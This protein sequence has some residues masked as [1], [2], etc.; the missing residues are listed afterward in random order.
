MSVAVCCVFYEKNQSMRTLWTK[1]LDYVYKQSQKQPLL[2]PYRALEHRYWSSLNMSPEWTSVLYQKQAALL[3]SSKTLIG[4][5]WWFDLY[6]SALWSW[7]LLCDI[8]LPGRFLKKWNRP[9]VSYCHGWLCVRCHSFPLFHPF[10]FSLNIKM[11]YELHH[12]C[13][14]GGVSLSFCRCNMFD[15]QIVIQRCLK[16]TPAKS[17]CAVE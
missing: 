14:Q 3:Y 17:Y 7:T 10:C 12:G 13:H 2:S 11:S 16:T 1:P 6:C 15:I 5:E 9:L 8:L 4:P